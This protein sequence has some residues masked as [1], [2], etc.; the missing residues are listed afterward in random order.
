MLNQFG[1]LLGGGDLSTAM[2]RIFLQNAKREARD[3]HRHVQLMQGR[4]KGAQ[5]YP[6][7]LFEAMVRGDE[8]TDRKRR[9]EFGEGQSQ[10]ST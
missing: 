6:Q 9:M 7:K 10:R 2:I 8:K 3:Q 1:Q 4:A 5:V